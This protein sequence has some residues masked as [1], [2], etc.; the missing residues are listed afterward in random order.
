VLQ[1]VVGFDLALQIANGCLDAGMIVASLESEKHESGRAGKGRGKP[2]KDVTV[3]VVDSAIVVG[4]IQ[5]QAK[6][7][8]H[9]WMGTETGP[10]QGQAGP[11]GR[12]HPC[13]I[14]LRPRPA[15]DVNVDIVHLGGAGIFGNSAA[16]GKH[17]CGRPVQRFSWFLEHSL[18]I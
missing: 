6:S 13:K 10:T 5:Q 18:D 3:A 2:P 4:S 9:S 11:S 15:H 16:I 1:I 14:I 8:L 7:F 12:L 17:S